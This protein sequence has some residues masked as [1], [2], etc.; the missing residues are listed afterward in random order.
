MLLS[1]CICWGVVL[2]QV[3]EERQ[4]E[5]LTRVQKGP[6]SYRF[7]SKAAVFVGYDSNVRLTPER[8]GDVFQ[9]TL[10]AFDF[11]KLLSRDLKATLDYDFDY[12][13]YNE[14]TDY[15][16]ILNH[17]RL[18]LHKKFIPCQ[19]GFGYDLGILY[20]PKNDDG[21]FLFHKGFVY[22]RKKILGMYHELKFEYGMKDYTENRAL[23]DTIATRQAKERLDRRLG[24]EYSFFVPLAKTAYLWFRSQFFTNDSNARYLDF[25]DYDSYRQSAGL[26][27]RLWPKLRFSTYFSYTLK[28]YD[29]R[30][31]TLGSE[32]QEDQLYA[33]TT[34]LTHALSKNISLSLFYTYRD[35]S[36]NEPF[37][38]YSENVIT[39]GCHY[40]F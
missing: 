24:A 2:A 34:G 31:V 33:V 8:D 6:P 28:K 27:C 16:S 4:E 9:E 21:N 1:G 3:S 20:Y 13:N 10:V 37:Q 18:G 35:N 40:N 11:S 22:A 32:K 23:G 38:E 39:C 17:L 26:D 7:S 12:I 15:S 36:S 5:R 30:T 14:F 19:A 25:Y 29:S